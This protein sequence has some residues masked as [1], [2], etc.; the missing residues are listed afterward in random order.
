MTTIDS[1]RGPLHCPSFFLM[2]LQYIFFMTDITET[3]FYF[4]TV[5]QGLCQGQ[6]ASIYN[7]H[8]FVK[9]YIKLQWYILSDKIRSDNTLSSGELD[10]TIICNNL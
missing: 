1:A 7:V 8:S 6:R 9:L 2:L 10:P 3:P 4:F 5:T